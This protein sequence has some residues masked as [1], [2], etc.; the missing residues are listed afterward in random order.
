MDG[1]NPMGVIRGGVNPK[2]DGPTGDDELTDK[3]YAKV[4]RH[5]RGGLDSVESSMKKQI[6]IVWGRVQ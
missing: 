3:D 6:G 4:I 1:M 2:E 5:I